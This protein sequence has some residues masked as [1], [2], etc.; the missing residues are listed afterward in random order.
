MATHPSISY[1]TRSPSRRPSLLFSKMNGETL[2][3]EYNRSKAVTKRDVQ[4]GTLH[5]V[6]LKLE[7]AVAGRRRLRLVGG[8]QPQPGW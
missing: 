8:G 1:G 5:P 2:I 7:Q 3:L 4:Q 6:L